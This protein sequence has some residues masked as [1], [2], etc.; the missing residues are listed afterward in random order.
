VQVQQ[1]QQGS[2]ARRWVT[3][4]VG[5]VAAVGLLAVVRGLLVAGDDGEGGG[6][7]GGGGDESCADPTFVVDVKTFTDE[8]VDPINVPQ[9]HTVT[10]E[11]T[12]TM[13]GRHPV[14]AGSVVVPMAASPE[15]LV[16]GSLEDPIL[17]PGVAAP[18]SAY[19]SVELT[20]SPVVIPD[21]TAAEVQWQ[22]EDAA[23]YVDC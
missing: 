8:P 22:Y 16:Y 17:E 6:T 15:A 19:G 11:G 21:D 2:G 13:T 10:L 7:G 1:E 4:V 3:V 23:H 18:F 5:V 9:M 14:N 20:G 12:V